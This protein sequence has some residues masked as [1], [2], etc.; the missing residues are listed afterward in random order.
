MWA[1]LRMQSPGAAAS[2]RFSGSAEA[3]EVHMKF[4]LGVYTSVSTKHAFTIATAQ[5]PEK[6]GFL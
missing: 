6:E 4:S 2:A 5:C 3:R 1:Q